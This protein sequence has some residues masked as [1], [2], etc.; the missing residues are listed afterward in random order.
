[1]VTTY[2]DI[3]LSPAPCQKLHH[4]DNCYCPVHSKGKDLRVSAWLPPSAPIPSLHQVGGPHRVCPR[5]PP[6]APRARAR[7]YAGRAVG[8]PGW[9]L[10]ARA[11]QASGES[12]DTEILA[13]APLSPLRGR[14][15][16]V[17]EVSTWVGTGGALDPRSRG[18]RSPRPPRRQARAHGRGKTAARSK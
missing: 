15:E 3:V 9:I 10:Q 16:G 13:F 11:R 18:R 14:P 5:L 6:S 17:C 7:A 4:R 12:V 1:M 8:S 2:Q